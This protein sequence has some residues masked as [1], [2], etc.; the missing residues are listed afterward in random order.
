MELFCKDLR[1]KAGV[2]LGRFSS[3]LKAWIFAY[4]CMLDSGYGHWILLW[5][6]G[7]NVARQECDYLGFGGLKCGWLE[8]YGP[9]CWGYDG[10]ALGLDS[11]WADLL[12]GLGML[13]GY[14]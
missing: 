11:F 6:R 13:L 9:E 3:T 2:L 10:E 14:V 1:A 12:V 8:C 7:M 4:G 5:S